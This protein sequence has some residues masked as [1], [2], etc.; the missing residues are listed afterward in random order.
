M[1]NISFKCNQCNKYDKF[2][3]K[4]YNNLLM[5]KYLKRFVC[6]S[7]L[8]LNR[9]KIKKI[10]HRDGNKLSKEQIYQL[11][12]NLNCTETFCKNHEKTWMDRMR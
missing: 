10:K 1:N 11:S 5:I 9:D 3:N 2:T 8:N 12:T 7:C 6:K 4:Q